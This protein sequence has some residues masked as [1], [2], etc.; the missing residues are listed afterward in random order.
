MAEEKSWVLTDVGANVWK[1]SLF[2]GHED[3]GVPDCTVSK[4]R[5]QG[6]LRSGVDLV[7][8]TNSELSF[9]IL[10]TRGMGLWKASCR[11]IPVGWES[12][13]KGPV[14]PK[15][16]DEGDRGG[17]GWLKGF[18]ECI[19]RCG[20]DSN[21]S[22]GED[23]IV[24][25][26]GNRVSVDLTLHGK[27]ANLPAHTL[28]VRS[29][30]GSGRVSVVGEVD[31]SSL[32]LPGLRLRSTVSTTPRSN[33][34]TVQDTITN[35]KT[36]PSELELVY[37]CNFGRPFLGAG[38][39]LLAAV[40]EV[41]PRDA[42]AVEGIGE[43]DS[44]LAPTPGYVEQ[45][46]FYDLAAGES[47]RTLVALRDAAGDRAVVL[48]F[49]KK[50]LPH[51]TQWKNTVGLSDGYVTGLE[52]GT[53][54]PNLKGFEREKGRVVVLPPGESYQCRL[55]LE[56]CTSRDQVAAVE[57]EVAR[58]QGGRR[59]AIHNRPHGKYSPV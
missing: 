14:H 3:L 23:V 55:E 7:E 19:V 33:R 26:N 32:F 17:L 25:N 52:P 51:F 58:I 12:P 37:H 49:N 16:V 4:T 9:S 29:D 40:L 54:Y 31:E 41:A 59:P 38:S 47:G 57:A 43:M 53:N 13:V 34:L 56:V 36:T 21:G 20:L 22:P 48:R 10:P 27:I 42:R 24:D 50:E 18:D 5:L 39:K 28:E 8:V 46:Y 30:P 35:L 6:G 44:Y 2:L 15:W 45:V 11:G 1:E